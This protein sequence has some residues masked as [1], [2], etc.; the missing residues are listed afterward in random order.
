MSEDT[1]QF[2][3]RLKAG[4]SKAIEELYKM[5][6]NYCAS[7]ILKNKGTKEDAKGVFQEALIVLYRNLNKPDFEI[8][9]SLKSYLYVI[10]KNIWYAKLRRIK[11]EKTDLIID[12]EESGVE[13]VNDDEA[14]ET[15]KEQEKMILLL[16]DQIKQL[17]EECRKLL[18]LFFYEKKN[19]KEVAA[20]M[21][22]KESYI[23]K[24]KM[25]CIEALRN[26]FFE[27]QKGLA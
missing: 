20:L 4:E 9:K 2:L 23:R 11:K 5:A 25:K 22:Y 12:E 18:R 26:N 6:F 14:L 8:K 1:Q 3:E 16:E 13:A 19:S 21:D 7:Y 24:K 27:A 17:K 15:K 10:T